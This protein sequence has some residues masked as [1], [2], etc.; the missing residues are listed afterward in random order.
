MRAILV[1]C[2]SLLAL[3]CGG[4]TQTA[5][6]PAAAQAPAPAAAAAGRGVLTT[7]DA[8]SAPK[9][10]EK[11]PPG[12]L[13]GAEVGEPA[14]TPPPGGFLSKDQI[15]EVMRAHQGEIRYCYERELVKNPSLAGTVVVKLVIGASGTVASATV[16]SSTL[17]SPPVE[18]CIARAVTSFTFPPPRGGGIVIVSY[19]YRLQTSDATAP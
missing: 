7:R 8:P 1:A 10:L 11:L 17:A 12:S 13:V 4:P 2:V 14:D 5:P 3:A 6:P 18:D 15:R 16:A 9:G 19:P